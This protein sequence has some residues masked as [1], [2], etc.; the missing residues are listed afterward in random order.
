MGTTAQKLNKILET[1]EAIR[2]AINNKGGTLTTTDT[3]ASYPSAIDS[4]PS[5]GGDPLKEFLDETKS[6][7]YLF[8]GRT[9]NSGEYSTWY[10]NLTYERLQKILNYDTTSSVTNIIGMFYY[11][12]KLTEIPLIDTSKVTDMSYMFSNCYKLQAIPPLN[13]SNV[14]N[15]ENMFDSCYELTSLPALNAQSLN[16]SPYN[17]VFGYNELANLVNFGG[18]LN[19]KCSLITN[20]NLRRLP[21]LTYESCINILN[22]L[23]DFRGNGDNNTTSTLNVHQNFLDK[24]GDEISIGTSKGWTITV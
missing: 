15:M 24:V 8:S 1:K 13:T 19:L 12:N 17:G 21:N 11:C 18:F 2:T 5:G 16:M 4:L 22:G 10:Y 14:T 3:F 7:S 20:K 9:Y 6:A 23:Y